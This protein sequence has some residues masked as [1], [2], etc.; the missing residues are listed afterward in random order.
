[1]IR[2]KKQIKTL[3]QANGLKFFF[4]YRSSPG[5]GPMSP[6]TMLAKFDFVS[7]NI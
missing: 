3:R 7:N 4:Y 1:M 2:K 6:L 5:G